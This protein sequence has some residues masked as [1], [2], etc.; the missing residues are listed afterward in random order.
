MTLV[1]DAGALIGIER[2]DR[3]VVAL[4]KGERLAGRTPLTHGGVVGQ[5]WRG[6]AGRQAVLSRLLPGI[7]IAALDD[8]LGR[9]AGVML[10]RSGSTDVVDAA[11]VALCRDG[12]T[13]LT[14]DPG[15]L[16]ALARAAGV[17]VDIV[18]V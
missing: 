5:V 7:E 6:G 13:V 9:I 15:D 11:V 8:R 17:H 10:G 12:D 14:S 3:D 16:V 1:L 4:V 18:S 2:S